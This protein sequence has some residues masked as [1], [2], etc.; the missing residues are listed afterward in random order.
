[1]AATDYRAQLKQTVST[2]SVDEQAMTFLRAFVADFQGKFEEVLKVAEEFKSFAQPGRIQELDEFEAHRFLEKKNQTAT[3]LKMREKLQSVD[4]SMAS[5]R[6][7]SFLEYLLF[8][9]NKTLKD[10]YTAK[11]NAALLAKLEKAINEY[12]AH[13][14][15]KKK[16]EA[17]MADLESRAQSGDVKAKAELNRLKMKDPAAD[18]KNELGALQ[19][20]LA[21]K[22][23]LANP[24]EE[25]ERI[26]REE[27]QRVAEEKRRQEAE[28]AKKKQESKNRL[29]AKA[30][31]FK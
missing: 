12:K 29:A 23:A 9:N 28:E 1:M 21:A 15:E 18:A 7:L 13:F 31:M 20:K 25:E 16:R 5:S 24:K 4:L 19:A 22:R 30:A 2:Q 17:E 26:Y 8:V 6:K 3:V 11:P 10:L 14:E 27:Q